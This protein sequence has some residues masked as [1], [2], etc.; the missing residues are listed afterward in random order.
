[1]A[2]NSSWRDELEYETT[3]TF[4]SKYHFIGYM[5]KNDHSAVVRALGIG[6]QEEVAV[7]FIRREDVSGCIS[8]SPLL[9][10][11]H[12][13]L[14][15]VKKTVD[16]HCVTVMITEYFEG[17][18]V[19]KLVE[20]HKAIGSK[21]VRSIF[22]QLLSAMN[23]MHLHNIVWSEI[24]LAHIFVDSEYNIKVSRMDGAF[25]CEKKNSLEAARHFRRD[26]ALLGKCLMALLSL[27]DT[28]TEIGENIPHGIIE[29]ESINN[30]GVFELQRILNYIIESRLQPRISEIY[31]ILCINQRTYNDKPFIPIIDPLIVDILNSYGI[32]TSNMERAVNDP[33]SREHSQYHLCCKLLR[34]DLFVLKRPRRI[35]MPWDTKIP[36]ITYTGL[37]ERQDLLRRRHDLIGAMI[38]RK[39]SLYEYF[40]CSTPRKRICFTLLWPMKPWDISS[41]LSGM[42]AKSYRIGDKIYLT[43]EESRIK[44]E[45]SVIEDNGLFSPLNPLPTRRRLQFV[46][47]Y[48][49]DHDFVESVIN[50]M[51]S[52]RQCF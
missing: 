16:L 25:F 9:L 11:N 12:K 8:I 29:N 52:I 2:A 13:A 7:R 37:K 39:P 31:H 6:E 18:S 43:N 46:K 32:D 40:S 17:P 26:I 41:I 23:Y 14:A 27:A 1:M 50:T 3:L 22:L 34:R 42:T 20:S 38:V 48:G 36:H 30:H 47:I 15:R 19:E 33:W 49:S 35:M 4:M 45:C 10:A 28:N 24:D 21:A 51:D 44:L 5:E